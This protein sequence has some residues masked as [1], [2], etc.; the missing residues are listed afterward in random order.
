[1]AARRETH[2]IQ[3]ETEQDQAGERHA[4]PSTSPALAPSGV[5]ARVLEIG[6]RIILEE[7]E[8]LERL[9]AYDR[10]AWRRR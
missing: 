6:Q 8:V 9:E 4:R 5:R 1:M 3:V 2:N 7:R 10:G